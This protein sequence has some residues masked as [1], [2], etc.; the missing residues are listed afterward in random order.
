[1]ITAYHEIKDINY[2]EDRD[3]KVKE[4]LRK[5]RKFFDILIL[6]VKKL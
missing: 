3:K 1:M 6:S 5:Y 4:I 2:V